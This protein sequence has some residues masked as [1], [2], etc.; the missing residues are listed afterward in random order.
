MSYTIVLGVIGG[1]LLVLVCLIGFL[2]T[3]GYG[4][5]KGSKLD[6]ESHFTSLINLLPG[7]FLPFLVFFLTFLSFFFPAC[8]LDIPCPPMEH[9]M[10]HLEKMLSPLKHERR[11]AVCD[12]ANSEVHQL[13]VV[14]HASIFVNTGTEATRIFNEIMTKGPIYHA[15]R[16]FMK[17]P[18]MF[19]SDEEAWKK[20]FDVMG[21]A[22]NNISMPNE[23]DI[24]ADLMGVL[25]EASESGEALDVSKTCTLMGFDM[26]STAVFGYVL[27]GVAGSK[28][29]EELYKSL[30]TLSEKQAGEGLYANPNAR[31]ISP[32]EEADAKNTW[33]V[34][35]KKCLDVL[36][37]EADNNSRS[38][39][40]VFGR[41]LRAF[42]ESAAPSEG[43]KNENIENI[44]LA[45]VHQIMRH[46]H[47]A[48][49]GMLIWLLVCLHQW[50]DARRSLESAIKEG[51]G[52][53]GEVEYVECFIR[54]TLRRYP[55]CGNMTV[56]T[57]DKD[58]FVLKGGYPVA[59]NTPIFLHIFSLQN[60]G[61]EW[62]KARDF[63][64]ERWLEENASKTGVN[65][66]NEPVPNAPRCP[67][68]A[69]G[70]NQT[71]VEKLKSSKAFRESAYGGLGHS[72]GSLSFLPFGV[73]AR[74][75]SGRHLAL[76]VM[77]K[78][79]FDV[80]SSHRLNPA[81]KPG[82]DV[83]PGASAFA[84]IVPLL[85]AST[86]LKVTRIGGGDTGL[87]ADVKLLKKMENSDEGWADDSDEDE[88]PHLE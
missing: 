48:I 82:M 28:E 29:G 15:Y 63:W 6:G 17:I 26:I 73:G 31:K 18:D 2:F 24:T 54:E 69:T 84:T 83:D 42:A 65:A 40:G 50:P 39:Q 44:M 58:G 86:N 13:V 9:H 88:V 59:V 22:L 70:S 51:R 14:K 68:V 16:F 67:F 85:K 34:F 71:V 78:F 21:E 38:K 81:E 47:E 75:C 37:T 41:A 23:D 33:K 80:A 64:P 49:G 20:R 55:T 66:K 46:G 74:T 43:N 8:T 76:Q 52:R 62:S 79:L 4:K 36:M 19:A 45:E 56:R 12:A 7:H 30:E 1:V 60:T 87:G 32:E 5:I 3:R 53:R 25:N 11:L 57:V 77:R 61:R 35:I 10:G 72:K 27:G